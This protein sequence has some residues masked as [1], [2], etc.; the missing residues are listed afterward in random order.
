MRDIFA[1]LPRVVK[2]GGY[3]YR[4]K[5]V[6]TDD[7]NLAHPADPEQR[8]DGMTYETTQRIYLDATMHPQRAAVVV[9]HELIHAINSVYGVTDESTEEQVTTQI[10]TGL[11]AFWRDNPKVFTWLNSARKLEEESEEKE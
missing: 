6:A 2:I 7:P 9:L 1:R 10:S 11:M 3:T 5:V 8:C 4:I